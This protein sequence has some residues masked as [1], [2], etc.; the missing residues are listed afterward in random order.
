[1]H[2][3]DDGRV[4]RLFRHVVGFAL[5]RHDIE[6]AGLVVGTHDAAFPAAAPTLRHSIHVTTQH[7]QH[8]HIIQDI[9]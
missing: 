7:K 5:I 2:D 9:E 6:K 1:M 4:L 8:E 3:R